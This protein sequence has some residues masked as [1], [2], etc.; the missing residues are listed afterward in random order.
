MNLGWSDGLPEHD[1]RDDMA[2]EYMEVVR[3]L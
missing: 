3:R 2:N 1:T